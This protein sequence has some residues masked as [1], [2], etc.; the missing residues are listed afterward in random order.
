MI[1]GNNEQVILT[2]TLNNLRN[3]LVKVRKRV[4]VSHRIVAVTVNHVGINKVGEAQTVKVFAGSLNSLL[5]SVCVAGGELKLGHATMSKDVINLAN[6]KNIKAVL[7][8]AI[9]HGWTR[10]LKR[11]VM[12]ARSALVWPLPLKR[13]SNN[14]SNTVLTLQNL[15]RNAAILIEFL[16][17]YHVLM[18][19][20]LE[21]RIC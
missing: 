16:G 6:R 2:K 9:K 10:W 14:A 20:N 19:S 12:T 4:G 18:S 5:N 1:C 7:F 8:K 13:T 17:T 15:A 3:A 11:E 21:N